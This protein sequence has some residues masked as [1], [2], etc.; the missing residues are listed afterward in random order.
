MRGHDI[1]STSF[2]L[3]TRSQAL[4]IPSLRMPVSMMS[5]LCHYLR[6]PPE[7][8]LP[9]TRVLAL[10][11]F[12]AKTVADLSRRFGQLGQ[13]GKAPAAEKITWILFQNLILMGVFFTIPLYL[14]LVIGL[15]ALDTG[16]KMLPVSIAMFVASAAGYARGDT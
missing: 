8:L 7:V 2:W 13:G 5:S 11:L 1:F 15:D 12:G 10:K 16:L 14:Q 3:S 6:A 9:L 4:L